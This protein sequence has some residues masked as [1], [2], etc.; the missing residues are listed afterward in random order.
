MT[1]DT[2]SKSQ[3][4]RIVLVDDSPDDRAEMR[5]LLLRSE[6]RRYELVDADTGAEAVAAVLDPGRG[7][8]SCVL[9]DYFLPD[10]DGQEVLSKFLR[11]SGL[12]VCPVIVI[13]GVDEQYGRAV[14]RLGA[15]DYIGKD[16]LTPRSL[17][18]TIENAVER[19][20]M[21]NELHD[22]DAVIRE[23]DEQI[24][25]TFEAAAVEER[26]RRRIAAD[27]HDGVGSSLAA[28]QL[29]LDALRVAPGE[30]A[31]AALTGELSA[32]LA[33]SIDAMRSLMF[34]L[35]PPILYDLGLTA[36]LGWLTEEIEKRYGLR[37]TFDEQV[38][39]FPLDE[40]IA[41]SLFRVVRELLINVSK[42]ARVAE[43]NLVLRREKD[44]VRIEVIDGGAGFEKG[45]RGNGYGFG[46]FNVRERISRLG[47]T[48]EIKTA[49]GEG[50]H[51]TLSVPLPVDR[52]KEEF[53]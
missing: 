42:H 32:L 12:L 10:M 30:S 4:W 40:V 53:T 46:L 1:G 41:A 28:A 21:A 45:V 44:R 36:A 52:A 2:E 38:S 34:D 19:W 20:A 11:P 49:P 22:R 8:P 6:T 5:R 15:Q 48:V 31:R 33:Q 29:K 27:L 37:V 23:R 50:T 51:V 7:P 13:T 25:M 9:L 26:E 14:L 17:A 35:S 24:A 39:E 3:V 16:G 43:A 47:G 18:R